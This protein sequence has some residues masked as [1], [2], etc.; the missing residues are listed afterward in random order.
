MLENGGYRNILNDRQTTNTKT[1]HPF[2]RIAGIEEK[3]LWH[4]KLAKAKNMLLQA[5]YTQ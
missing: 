2:S 5:H 3:I 1:L 4:S